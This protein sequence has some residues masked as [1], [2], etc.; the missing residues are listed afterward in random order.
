MPNED[1]M[2]RLGIMCPFNGKGRPLMCMLHI[3]VDDTWQPSASNTFKGFVVALLLITGVPS[4]INIC[5]VPESA[6]ALPV[7]R[8][9]I[10]PAKLLDIKKW[11]RAQDLNNF[12]YNTFDA[13][14]V[15]SSSLLCCKDVIK[16]GV[17]YDRCVL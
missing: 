7:L 8:G 15:S 12:E 4:I 6:I 13:M 1:A 16:S 5:V 2:E 9:N 14:T 10:A 11:S 3:R 17:G